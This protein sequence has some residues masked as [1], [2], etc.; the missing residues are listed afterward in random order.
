MGIFKSDILS[1]SFFSDVNFFSY[2]SVTCLRELYQDILYY[3]LL[4]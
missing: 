1:I 3:V 2:R 4:L